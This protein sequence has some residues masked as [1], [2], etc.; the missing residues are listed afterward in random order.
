MHGSSLNG[1]QG[2]GPSES[3]LLNRTLPTIVPHDIKLMAGMKSATWLKIPFEILVK[4]WF[5]IRV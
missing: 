2:R 1:F 4:I 5:E 3:E